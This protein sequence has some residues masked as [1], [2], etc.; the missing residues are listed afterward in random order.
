MRILI[1]IL[2][3]SVTLFSFNIAYSQP[4]VLD[5]D[6]K[7]EKFAEGLTFPIAMVFIDDELFV[8]E[9]N[10]GKILKISENGI[11]SENVIV[12]Q[13][14]INR[15]KAHCNKFDTNC[16]NSSFMREYA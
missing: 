11:V 16:N 13:N 14:V 4:V 2:V 5:E 6:Y 9:K 15:S 10:S 7:I 1:I 12:T 8:T 3:L